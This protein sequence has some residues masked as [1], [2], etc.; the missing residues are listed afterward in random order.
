MTGRVSTF[1]PPVLVCLLGSFRVLAEGRPI[2]MKPGGKVQ[3]LLANLAL[4][5]PFGVPRDELLDTL[6]PSAE[7]TLAAQSL[8]TLVYS[9]H[10]S[11]GSA[12][13][14]RPPIRHVDGMYRLN[15]EDGVAVDVAAFDAAADDGDRAARAGDDAAALS[16]YSGAA[17][18]YQ[19]DLVVTADVRQLVERERLRGRYLMIQARLAELRFRDG[20]H[21]GALRGALDVLT[22][23]PCREDAHRLAMRA[24]NR[25][26]Q[27]SQALRQFRICRDA[28]AAEFDAVPEPATEDLF[29]QLRREPDRV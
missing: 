8:N 28:L 7:P 5:P 24:Y 12:L 4:H 20:D 6:W 17:E 26:G 2:S 22:H 23:D 13:H 21:A 15:V 16:S 25:L 9:L 29:L 19:G 3:G 27:R 18:V 1:R 14:G 11:L 10:R